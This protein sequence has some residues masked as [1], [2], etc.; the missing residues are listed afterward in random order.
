MPDPRQQQIQS[1]AAFGVGQGLN[2]VDDDRSGRSQRLGP[3]DQ[4][5]VHLFVDHDGDVEIAALDAPIR[6]EL[7]TIMT[8]FHIQSKMTSITV[9]HDIEEAVFLGQ[10]I[11]VFSG[12]DSQSLTTIDN[13][14][15]G[16]SE[17][18]STTHFQNQCHRLHAILE[19]KR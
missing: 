8:R 15:A 14:L 11:L 4:V 2:L 10:K 19:G 16:Q 7:Q 3:R 6:I 17:A 5:V 13:P 1:A 18:R 12:R 9:T